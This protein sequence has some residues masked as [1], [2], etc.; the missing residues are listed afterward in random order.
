VK[1]APVHDDDGI[2]AATAALAREPGGGLIIKP[3]SFNVTNRDVII[4]AAARHSLPLV[5][6]DITFFP[7]AGGLLSYWIDAA[8]LH[9]EAASYINRILRRDPG[10]SP[11]SVPDE[12][13][14]DHQ[15]EDRQGAGPH[16]AANYARSRR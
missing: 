4:A 2:E 6:F 15:P 11:R 9:A 8:K 10:R 3:D 14:P 1:L 5:S 7:R 16:C 12:I 13:L